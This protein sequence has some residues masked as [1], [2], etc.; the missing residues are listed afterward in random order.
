[1]ETTTGRLRAVWALSER[2]PRTHRT[3]VGVAWENDDQ[4]IALRLDAVP[5]QGRLLIGGWL[6]EA[7]AVL[8][9]EVIS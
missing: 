4:T 9:R 5:I 1:M 6:P 3:R 2:G 7:E 8:A